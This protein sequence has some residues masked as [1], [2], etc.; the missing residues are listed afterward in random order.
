MTLCK[1]SD[2]AARRAGATRAATPDR[3]P[4]AANRVL[5]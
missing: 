2:L 5:L 4:T 3:W 1:Q